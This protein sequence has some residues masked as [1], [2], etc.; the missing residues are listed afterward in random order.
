M[1]LI[2]KILGKFGLVIIPIKPTQYLL[3]SMAVRQ[4][5]AFGMSAGMADEE[6]NKIRQESLI[7]GNQLLTSREKRAAINEMVQL[8][9]EVVLRGFYN[10]ELEKTNK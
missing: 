8:H 5:H 1:K 2:N 7:F 3:N 9:E 4:N 6:I 10:P